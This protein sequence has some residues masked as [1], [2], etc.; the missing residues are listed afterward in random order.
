MDDVTLSQ[1]SPFRFWTVLQVRASKYGGVNLPLQGAS[2]ATL[3]AR[4]PPNTTF[5]MAG[6][7][8]QTSLRPTVDW[9]RVR[10][11]VIFGHRKQCRRRDLKEKDDLS[12]VYVLPIG[13][14]MM[15][16][17]HSA[18]FGGWQALLNYGL[19]STK[20]PSTNK[21]LLAY[22]EST[23]DS[24]LAHFRHIVI[25]GKI[26]S[27]TPCET[28]PNHFNRL[29]CQCDWMSYNCID[30]DRRHAARLQ[31]PGDAF[32]TSD[33]RALFGVDTFV[34]RARAIDRAPFESYSFYNLRNDPITT[35]PPPVDQSRAMA[36]KRVKHALCANCI[37][38]GRDHKGKVKR[39]AIRCPS[40]CTSLILPDDA[41]AAMNSVEARVVDVL[42]SDDR[43]NAADFRS[44]YDHCGWYAHRRA[45][46]TADNALAVDSA[47]SKA[48]FVAVVGGYRRY[49]EKVRN[50][51]DS[52]VHENALED[53]V[54]VFLRPALC[55]PRK[56]DLYDMYAVSYTQFCRLTNRDPVGSWGQLCD[57]RPALNSLTYVDKVNLAALSARV[58]PK[59]YVV[60]ASRS[61]SVEY[62][63]T[64][65][66]QL[67]V[68]LD[69]R[70]SLLFNRD[71][72]STERDQEN[73][74]LFSRCRAPQ[75]GVIHLSLP[76]LR[77]QWKERLVKGSASSL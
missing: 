52:R 56:T 10:N 65:H 44:A 75:T 15:M 33:L 17:A 5:D 57:R 32:H 4:L 25:D 45:F 73:Q 40:V 9:T 59:T 18:H 68:E 19:L 23:R 54:V 6:A 76:K 26:V 66:H 3:G 69:G 67:R 70:K 50:H 47:M 36:T 1:A 74:W 20:Y 53:G 22:A 39:C 37:Y 28:C 29:L 7:V 35:A 16:S 38:V 41:D 46:L 60:A 64:R 72:L 31:D 21:L 30:G 8:I 34:D 61:I 11:G 58:S 48:E 71:L 24:E 13:V 62:R 12:V 77:Q 43:I 51:I 42:M 49:Y 14:V 55:S 2:Y 27:E 63:D